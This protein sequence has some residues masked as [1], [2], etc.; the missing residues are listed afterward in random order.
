MLLVFFKSL[1][2][3]AK[4]KLFLNGAHLYLS[5]LCHY[6]G[7]ITHIRTRITKYYEFIKGSRD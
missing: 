5:L 7:T 6:T 2:K 3:Y 1:H 4:L